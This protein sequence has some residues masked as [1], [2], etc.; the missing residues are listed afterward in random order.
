[1]G[2]NRV[3]AQSQEAIES[4]FQIIKIKKFFKNHKQFVRVL[5][6]MLI[7]RENYRNYLDNIVG[8]DCYKV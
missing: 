5:E 6:L 1:M 3:F 8:Q 2:P 7:Y 4:M